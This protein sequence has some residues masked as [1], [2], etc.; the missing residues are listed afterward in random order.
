MSTLKL[1]NF[2]KQQNIF[3]WTSNLK[4]RCFNNSAIQGYISNS[5]IHPQY[6][7]GLAP[8]LIRFFSTKS[9]TSIFV[10]TRTGNLFKYS[11]FSNCAEALGISR[12]TIRKAIQENK[13]YK[14]YFFSLNLVELDYLQ[15]LGFLVL[16]NSTIDNCTSLVP[17]GSNLTS[18]VS[19]SRF[20]KQYRNLMIIAKDKLEII[21]G[22]LLSD[23]HLS[24]PYRLTRG[25][26]Y[27]NNSYLVLKQSLSHFEY[28]WF[29]FNELSH[30][31][32]GYP[33]LKIS[34]RNNRICYA[35]EFV[36]RTLP[37]FMELRNIYYTSEGIKK[38][39]E[40]IYNIITPRALAHL[41]M[42]DGEARNFG[43]G[44]CTHSYTIPDV[45]RLMN[46]LIIRYDFK[47]TIRFHN[48]QP[49][50]YISQ[51]SMKQLRLIVSPF[52]CSS[53]LYKLGFR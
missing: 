44:L 15:N 37:C 5:F 32:S 31:C 9:N 39:P 46:A 42:G 8:N 16:N 52:I 27:N 30:Y 23:G 49:T 10:Y 53:M 25:K 36:T 24:N 22:I 47:C 48:N 51:H 38:I 19:Y 45:V 29:T 7:S 28:L 34:K 41:I 1:N 50:I 26:V 13:P 20:S 21:H 6:I 3:S 17:F 14:H 4:I 12:T 43:L 2:L 40:D 11:N 35:V 18:N 33:V